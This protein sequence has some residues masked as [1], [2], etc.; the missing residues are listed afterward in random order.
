MISF[1][2]HKISVLFIQAKP[3]AHLQGGAWGQSPPQSK[4][5][6]QILKF[7]NEQKNMLKEGERISGREGRVR[8]ENN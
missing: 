5:I 1:K 3:L 4:K 8:E 6:W 7:L 2:E